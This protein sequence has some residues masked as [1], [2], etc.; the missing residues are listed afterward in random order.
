MKTRTPKGFPCWFL[1][2]AGAGCAGGGFHA[3]WRLARRGAPIG[4]CVEESAGDWAPE[5][6]RGPAEVLRA[7]RTLG[8]DYPQTAGLMSWLAEV[9][10]AAAADAW[11]STA[12]PGLGATAG[13]AAFGV[14]ALG[15]PGPRRQRALGA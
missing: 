13:A 15:G 5:V 2:A 9:G 4:T 10:R 1:L 3:G 8:W 14:W 12:G 11:S 7:W 6:L